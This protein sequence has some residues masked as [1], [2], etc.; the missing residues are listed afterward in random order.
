MNVEDAR[1]YYE[2]ELASLAAQHRY[3]AAAQREVA[4][5][6]SIIPQE[7]ASVAWA[8][9]CLDAAEGRPV[10]WGKLKAD[11][12]A[13][14]EETAQLLDCIRNPGGEPA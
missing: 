11:L 8:K 14:R 13:A 9:G 6:M 10:D 3:V 5:R 7:T 2:R 12:Y 1:A 4:L